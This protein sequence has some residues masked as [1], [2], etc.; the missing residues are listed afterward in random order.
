MLDLSTWIPLLD[1]RRTEH[2]RILVEGL[3]PAVF[4]IKLFFVTAVNR[5]YKIYVNTS[6]R[7]QNL[8]CQI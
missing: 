5:K 2:Q 6:S 7:F 3:D 4:L 1:T 8:I